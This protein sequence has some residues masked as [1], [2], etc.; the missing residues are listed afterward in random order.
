MKTFNLI[1][2]L[3]YILLNFP[4]FAE[5]SPIK[6][7]K[8]G[9]VTFISGGVGS[10]EQAAIQAV[11]GDY[12]LNLLFSAKGTGE[13][14]SDAKVNIADST[15][16]PVLDT[17]AE[18]PMLLAKLKPGNYTVTAELDGK[19]SHK[20]AKIGNKGRSALSFIW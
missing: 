9:E 17:V 7:Q 1:L 14:L 13:Y 6:P 5:E 3:T 10:D 16:N 20:K 2:I 15:G 11:R 8:Q 18:G 19:V 4:S 12:N